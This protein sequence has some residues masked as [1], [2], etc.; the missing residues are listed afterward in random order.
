MKRSKLLVLLVAILWLMCSC[1][2]PKTSDGSK[3][4][5]Y[6]TPMSDVPAIEDII[7]YEINLRAFSVSGD[8]QGVIQRLPALEDL[9]IN[10][11]WLMPIHPI[12]EINSVNSPYSVKDY[13]EISAEYGSLEDLRELSDK[14][15][16][17]GMAVI[18]DWVANH[19]AWDNPWINNKSWYTL[20]QN[21][22]IISP[23]GTNWLDVADLNHYNSSMQ[24]A[25]IDAMEYWILEANIDGYRCD[26]ADGVP[27]DFWSKALTELS[28]TPDR[29]LIFLA[30]G[31]RSDHYQ[32]GF[33]LTYGWSFY[34]SMKSVFNGAAASLLF[35]TN[36]EEYSG[37]P[38]GSDI[39]RFTTNHDESAWDATP[40]VLFKG[41]QGALAASIATIFMGGVP[42]IYTGQEVGRE[43]S[44]PFFSNSPINWN[45]NPELLLSY[46]Q[47]LELYTNSQA[48][49]VGALSSFPDDDILCFTRSNEFETLHIM[50][51]LR[52]ETIQFNTPED[53]QNGEW[54]DMLANS[55]LSLNSPLMLDPFQ[56]FI[57]KQ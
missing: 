44:I 32:A 3:Y 24:D 6:S 12:G 31:S 43:Q 20:D 27:L 17:R 47:V 9:G 45:A 19:T 42:L 48:A 38:E 56:F 2:E 15:H 37:V 28:S 41:K 18:M 40:I 23:P 4:T 11:I 34:G 13:K 49:K 55:S 53:L 50:V 26:Y 51:N 5:Q 33:D 22:E 25:M 1:E 14:A 39:L 8:L 21:Y 36:S 35:D 10:V 29:Q 30:E 46:Q 52:N 54:Q 7:M 16:E 57:L